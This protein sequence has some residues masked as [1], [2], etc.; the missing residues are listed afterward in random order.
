MPSLSGTPSLM[1]TLLL[2]NTTQRKLQIE[3][4]IHESSNPLKALQ[5]QKFAHVLNDHLHQEQISQTRSTIYRQDWCPTSVPSVAEEDEES[6]ET[7]EVRSYN[8][9]DS[10]DA[11]D[12]EHETVEE[13]DV[14]EVELDESCLVSDANTTT[15]KSHTLEQLDYDE[16]LTELDLT[17]MDL[18]DMPALSRQ[19]SQSP[20]PSLYLSDSGESDEDEESEDHSWSREDALHKFLHLQP[21]IAIQPAMLLGEKNELP[22][23]AFDMHA[24]NLPA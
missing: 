23:Y 17:D 19:D 1:R 14:D 6:E 2:L 13:I 24:L 18:Y 15:N 12:A 3:E 22:A 7:Y 9:L 11:F 16:D 10:A 4:P 8:V 5:L 20:I 21:H